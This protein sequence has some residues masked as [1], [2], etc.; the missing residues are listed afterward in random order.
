MAATSAAVLGHVGSGDKVIVQM[1]LYGNTHK[2]WFA[3][4]PRLGIEV[5]WV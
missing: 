1:G 5:V 3:L 2:F 4:A